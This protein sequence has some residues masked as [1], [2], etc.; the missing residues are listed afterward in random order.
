MGADSVVRSLARRGLEVVGQLP[1]STSTSSGTSASGNSNS[2]ARGAFSPPLMGTPLEPYANPTH[3]SAR[4]DTTPNILAG[5][6]LEEY[7]NPSPQWQ[8]AAGAAAAAL[9]QADA[10]LPPSGPASS[11]GG[12]SGSSGGRGRT[13]AAV[14]GAGGQTSGLGPSPRVQ[15][16]LQRLRRFMEEHVYPAGALRQL[17]RYLLC[18]SRMGSV[19][20]AAACACTHQAPKAM[21]CSLFPLGCSSSNLLRAACRTVRGRPE[22]VGDLLPMEGAGGPL[23]WVACTAGCRCCPCALSS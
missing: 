7:A 6:P 23:A 11:G 12:G 19:A 21:A 13:A 16:L 2:S 18:P 17:F 1:P 8:Q 10:Q 4:P 3:P 15:P 22:R 14:A 9:A 5:N 20:G